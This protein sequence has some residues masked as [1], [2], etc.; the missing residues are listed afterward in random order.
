M[1][2]ITLEKVIYILFQHLMNVG[3]GVEKITEIFISAQAKFNP[4]IKTIWMFE[5]GNFETFFF[6]R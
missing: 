4:N 2:R 5:N 6:L 1:K 3:I